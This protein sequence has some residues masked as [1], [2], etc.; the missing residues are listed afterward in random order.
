MKK[1]EELG[2]SGHL[3]KSVEEAKFESPTEIQEKS[4]PLV[5]KGKDV[6]AESATGS[7]KT[8]AFGA[9][10]INSSEK[11]KGIQG[12][13]LTPTRELAEQVAQALKEFSKFK[14]LNVSAVYGGVGIEPQ[15]RAL[16]K[17]DV[18]VGTPGRLLDHINRRTIN[19][20]NLKVLV[21]DEADRMID[22]GFIKDVEK[23]IGEC[24]NK[25]QTLLFSATISGDVDYIS[26]RYMKSPTRVSAEPQVDPTKL[27]QV[28][29]DIPSNLKFSLLMHLLK[30]EKAK[31]IMVFCNTQRNTDFVA[32]NLKFSGINAQAIHGGFSQ[33]KRKRTMERFHSRETQILVCTDVA[34]RGLDIKNVSHVYNYDIPRESN[35]YIH[36]IGRTARAGK[37]GIAISLVTDR[38]Y[39]EFSNILNKLG[40][41]IE[42]EKTP[43][44]S[45]TMIRWMEE[46][47]EARFGSRDN[48]EGRGGGHRQSFGRR[49][50]GGRERDGDRGRSRS[51]GGSGSRTGGSGGGH[52][53]SFGGGVRG[54]GRGG[55]FGGKRTGGGDGRGRSFGGGRS[56]GFRGRSSFGRGR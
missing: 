40:I 44:I 5:L 52:R 16:E 12:L 33:D 19:L 35:Q 27:K 36:R 20:E 4:I 22:M 46:K 25:R 28:Y 24:P 37:E 39:Q 30:N 29:Y 38:D 48:R 8:L 1:F 47:K 2:I 18:V 21:L 23:I 31:L 51:F 15:V 6:I 42:N 3:L 56:G 11:G 32:K 10:I 53:G 55:G 50:S 7:G 34:A 14:G 45:R 43:E 26:K 13:V 54:G 41:K 9:G 17:A 49:E